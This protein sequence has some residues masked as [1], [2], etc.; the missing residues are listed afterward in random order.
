MD[1]TNFEL[2]GERCQSSW[3]CCAAGGDDEHTAQ[4]VER[5]PPVGHRWDTD[6]SGPSVEP[7]PEV[8]SSR[9]LARR[10]AD[11]I[12][13]R[14]TPRSQVR[15][16]PQVEP[17]Q[18]RTEMKL[19][20][21]QLLWLGL[22]SFAVLAVLVRA[23]I[24]QVGTRAEDDPEQ[25]DE[26]NVVVAS[27]SKSTSSTIVATTTGTST[28]VSTVTPTSPRAT[29]PPRSPPFE[30]VGDGDYEIALTTTPLTTA[31]LTTTAPTLSTAVILFMTIRHLDYASLV[32]HPDLIA[33]VESGLEE[34]VSVEAGNSISP[35]EIRVAFGP[36]SVLVNATIF[37]LR[38]DVAR[39]IQSRLNSSTSLP[40]RMANTLHQLGLQNVSTG[41]L[42]VTDVN[43]VTSADTA[44]VAS[45][46]LPTYVPLLAVFAICLLL[47]LI[48]ACIYRPRR[49]D[50]YKRAPDERDARVPSKSVHDAGT[51][52]DVGPPKDTFQTLS[53]TPETAPIAPAQGI[54]HPVHGPSSLKNS[55]DDWDE[56]EEPVAPWMIEDSGESDNEPPWVG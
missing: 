30:I 42:D 12:P 51:F 31:G 50:G 3:P 54:S 26:A 15:V 34:A 22:L 56:T 38:E 19:R 8:L 55:V 45:T 10:G 4:R 33:N 11:G 40:R 37:S 2:C 23:A 21:I 1:Q 18:L 17:G 48:L 6:H 43:V 16:N 24:M 27:R 39:T 5:L 46:S 49:R 36:G 35:E 41:D 25:E 29:T 9:T 32:A 20:G 44:I 14:L 13:M 53:V 47:M 28:T 7:T 52:D